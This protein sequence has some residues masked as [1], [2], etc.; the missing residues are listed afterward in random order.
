MN[1]LLYMGQHTV[2]KGWYRE[3]PLD[4]QSLRPPPLLISHDSLGPCPYVDDRKFIHSLCG[5]GSLMINVRKQQLV[6]LSNTML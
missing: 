2:H 5:P 1:I 3:I 4:G 6:S